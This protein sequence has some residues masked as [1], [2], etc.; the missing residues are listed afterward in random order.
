MHIILSELTKLTDV[1]QMNISIL[2]ANFYSSYS[3]Y[4]HLLLNVQFYYRNRTLH[5]HYID[6][7]ALH[8]Q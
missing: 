2:Y 1:T 5:F 7:G 4:L 8:L 6:S 3:F